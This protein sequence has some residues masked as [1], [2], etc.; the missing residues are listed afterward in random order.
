MEQKEVYLWVEIN[1]NKERILKKELFLNIMDKCKI[2]GIDTIIL[3]VKNL[4]GSVIYHSRFAPHIGCF[5]RNFLIE[6]G[7]FTN[8]KL[9]P[10]Q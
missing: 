4:T 7:N 3:E 5:D 6:V 9:M 8:D 10:I 1:A 2:C